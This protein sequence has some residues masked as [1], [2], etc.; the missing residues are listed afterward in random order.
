MEN[1]CLINEALKRGIMSHEE[2]QNYVCPLELVSRF[3]S[4]EYVLI[5][6]EKIMMRLLLS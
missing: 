5:M 4:L 6:N 2:Y 1:V 3:M